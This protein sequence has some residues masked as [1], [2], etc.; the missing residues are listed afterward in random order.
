MEKPQG[1]NCV[2]AGLYLIKENKGFTVNYGFLVKYGKFLADGINIKI[3]IE[4]RP[5][6]AGLLKINL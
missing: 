2:R 6:F 5:N 1:S 3:T 4:K